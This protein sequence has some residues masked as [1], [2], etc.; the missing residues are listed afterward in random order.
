MN[1]V[2]RFQA[3]RSYTLIVTL[4][5][6]RSVLEIG[7]LTGF[8][9]LH[10]LKALLGKE[11]ARIVSVDKDPAYDRAFFADFPCV[12]LITGST[13]EILGTIPG[14]F[15]LVFVDS[16]HSLSTPER[17]WMLFINITHSGSIFLFHDVP[18]GKPRII[19]IPIQLEPI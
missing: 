10:R 1:L 5:D 8:T 13:P 17:R 19:H 12:A 11:G 16:N 6:S 15:D 7:G 14:D 9:T 4:T 2:V 3:R 18:P